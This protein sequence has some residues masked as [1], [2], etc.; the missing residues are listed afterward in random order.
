MSIILSPET[1]NC[2]CIALAGAEVVLRRDG[3]P[4]VFGDL[5]DLQGSSDDNMFFEEKHTDIC[6][7]GMPQTVS[8]PESFETTTLRNYFAE[9][10]DEESLPYFRAKALYE[11]LCKTRYCPIC[12][13]RLEP[14]TSEE[15]TS[16]VCPNCHN[17]IFPRIEP[18]I[19]VLVNR[20][21][22]ILLAL[23]RNRIS[24]Y[25]SCIAGFMEAG[26][27]AEQAVRREIM[28]ETGISVRNIRYFG[29]QSWPF[30][31]QL[32]LGFTAEYE[33]GE[34]HVQESEL[35]RA[36][37][38]PRDNCPATPPKGSIAYRLIHQE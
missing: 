38:F 9:H 14:G 10:G 18:C 16:L 36:A 26:E 31:S 22:D 32:M 1:S 17:I 23:H 21:D 33:S 30:P 15:E 12:G 28:E 29:S 13:T 3:R 27:S 20:G 24:K 4:L 25:Y 8:L 7:L 6:V 5:K 19:I 2:L 35:Q 11:W 37:W 34:I